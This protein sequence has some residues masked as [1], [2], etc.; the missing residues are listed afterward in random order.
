MIITNFVKH[1]CRVISSDVTITGI[2]NPY[3]IGKPGY[4]RILH[5]KHR[6]ITAV[7]KNTFRRYRVS[8]NFRRI[9]LKHIVG[10]TITLSYQ[11]AGGV[12]R[13]LNNVLVENDVGRTAHISIRVNI[14]GAIR[15]IQS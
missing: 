3:A 2:I 4:Q 10:I 13:T 11:W 12:A 7:F 8:Q 9:K 1:N 6:T 14:S 5:I 15:L